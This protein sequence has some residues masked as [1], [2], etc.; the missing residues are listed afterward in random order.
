MF[1]KQA[2]SIVR[3][4]DGARAVWL[5]GSAGSYEVVKAISVQGAPDEVFGT[6]L[7]RLSE[8]KVPLHGLVLGVAGSAATL[9][10][11][12]LPPVPDWRL[13]LILK[14]ETEEMA[15][16]SGEPLSS[17]YIPL[18]IPESAGDDEVH[19]LGMGKEHELLPQITQIEA[20]GGRVRQAIPNALGVIHGYLGSFKATPDETVL[21]ADIGEEESH[22]GIVREGRLL[23]ART[24]AFGTG[25]LDDLIGRRLDLAIA[26]AILVRQRAQTGHLPEEIRA[27]VEAT[28]RTWN[29]QLGQLVVSSVTFCRSQTKIQELSPDRLLLAGEGAALALSQNLSVLGVPDQIEPLDPNVSGESSG[30]PEEWAPVI[31]WAA[32]SLDSRGRRL[33]LLPSEFRKKREFRERTRFLYGAAGALILA[34]LLQGLAGKLEHTRA[35]KARSVAK[36]WRQKMSSWDQTEAQSKLSNQK[37]ENRENRLKEEIL[38]GSFTMEILDQ[39]SKEIPDAISLEKISTRRVDGDGEL[40]LEIMLEGSAD[41]ADGDGIDHLQSLREFFDLRP[42]IQRAVIKPGNLDQ[43]RYPFELL[44]SPDATMPEGSSGRSRRSPRS[45]RGSF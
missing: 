39:L 37:F 31:G 38:T 7:N 1:A 23:F 34:V 30:P 44:I 29:G 15:E 16:K 22:L 5:R 19:L 35:D 4:Q 21:I 32:A 26:E 13:K 43:G 40:G 28:L 2:V 9:R 6:L 14:Y 11:H 3:R 42:R 25:E 36:T 17:D 45:Q 8:E 20:V 41:N 10:Y 27:G 24:V 18:E 12:R 33:D